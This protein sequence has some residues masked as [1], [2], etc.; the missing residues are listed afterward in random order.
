[1][2]FS[3]GHILLFFFRYI[4]LP[5]WLAT[6]GQ[7]RKSNRDFIVGDDKER[8]CQP[9]ENGSVNKETAIWNDM[10]DCFSNSA[11]VGP[12]EKHVHMLNGDVRSMYYDVILHF[13]SKCTYYVTLVTSCPLLICCTQNCLARIL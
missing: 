8:Y 4:T 6:I 1:M 5:Q 3:I 9:F 2:Q 13:N 7:S 10:L 11:R 12:Q